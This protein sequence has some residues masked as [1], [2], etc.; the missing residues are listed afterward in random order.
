MGSND[1]WN[2]CI[3]VICL[4][5]TLAGMSYLIWYGDHL[6]KE[7]EVYSNIDASECR[8]LDRQSDT[9]SCGDDCTGREYEYTV[10]SIDCPG[11]HLIS[12]HNECLD[13]AY[14]IFQ[15]KEY[16]DNYLVHFNQTDECFIRSCSS[17]KFIWSLEKSEL[18]PTTAYICIVIGSLVLACVCC[19]L[20]FGIWMIMCDK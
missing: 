2:T 5:G 17:R 7:H 13:E 14:G 16:V 20:V 4:L 9:C 10:I 1:A 11:V 6:L 15:D 3:G 12:E 18:N 19:F 8:V